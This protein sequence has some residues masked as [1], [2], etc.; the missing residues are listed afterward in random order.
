MNNSQIIGLFN[1][2]PVLNI[3]LENFREELRLWVSRWVRFSFREASAEHEDG[4]ET[5]AEHEDGCAGGGKQR[6]TAWGPLACRRA[7]LPLVP[8]SG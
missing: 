1:S 5:S 8:A 7:A 4:Q 6:S 3:T 2:S